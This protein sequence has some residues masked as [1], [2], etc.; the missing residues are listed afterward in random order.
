MKTTD[1]ISVPWDPPIGMASY[2]G[3]SELCDMEARSLRIVVRSLVKDVTLPLDAL[4]IVY[5]FVRDNIVYS[6]P[7]KI[8]YKASDVL[9]VGGSDSV[10]KTIL[11][12]TMLKLV[13][14]P[15]RFHVGMAN[16]DYLN[17]LQIGPL[18]YFIPRLLLH[19][20]VEAWNGDRF[21]TLEGVTV[22][23]HYIRKVASVI[24]TDE[25]SYGLGLADPRPIGVMANQLDWDG[26]TDTYCQRASV[27]SDLGDHSQIEIV[28]KANEGKGLGNLI[29]RKI[30]TPSI[31]RQIARLRSL[32]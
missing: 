5:N 28:V 18:Q 7:S 3:K 11:L 12:A 15:I 6:I 23:R 9:G 14:I 16:S 30:T 22:D 17:G 29:Y 31:T 4:R 19:L 32:I 13:S 8:D 20:W 24:N 25:P 2:L 1:A 10:G 27:V 26:K 21:V